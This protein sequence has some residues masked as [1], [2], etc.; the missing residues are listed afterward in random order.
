MEGVLTVVVHTNLVAATMEGARMTVLVNR[1]MAAS[2]AT[3]QLL[4]QDL[5]LVKLA[6]LIRGVPGVRDPFWKPSQPRGQF[7]TLR[8]L[9]NPRAIAS[10]SLSLI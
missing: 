9:C 3:T 6:N 4:P 8:K 2:G 5:L 7:V 1:T 10:T